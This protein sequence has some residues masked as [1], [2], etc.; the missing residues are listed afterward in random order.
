MGVRLMLS[1]HQQIGLIA[2]GAVS[3]VGI[4]QQRSPQAY[5]PRPQCDHSSTEPAHSTAGAIR[6]TLLPRCDVG[7]HVI[8]RYLNQK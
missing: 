5:P 2:V 6:I 3:T 4:A 7:V 8:D 1:M